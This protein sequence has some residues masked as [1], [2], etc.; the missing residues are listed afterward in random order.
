M[1]DDNKTAQLFKQAITG[2]DEVRKTNWRN[3]FPEYIDWIDS[4][5]CR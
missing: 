2:I 4:I 3:V 1:T 5:K